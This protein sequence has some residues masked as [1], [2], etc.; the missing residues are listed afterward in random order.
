MD[1]GVDSLMA[2]ELRNVLGTALKRSLPTTLLFD[3]PSIEALV[4]YLAQEVLGFND[5]DQ[6]PAAGSAPAG[7]SSADLLSAIE[8]LS[9][10]EVE[11]MIGNQTGENPQ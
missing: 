4:D 8:S 3:Y 2:V 6:R 9:D 7:S 11:R 5:V 1:L 10:E